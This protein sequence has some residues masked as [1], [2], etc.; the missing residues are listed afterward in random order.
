MSKDNMVDWVVTCLYKKTGYSNA[1]ARRR[2]RRNARAVLKFGDR[3]TLNVP[4]A[5]A[6][7]NKLV[8]KCEVVVWGGVRALEP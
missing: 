5:A 1:H 2:R 8:E 4:D 6:E 7:L 3:A